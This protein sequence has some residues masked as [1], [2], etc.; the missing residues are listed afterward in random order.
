MKQDA[1]LRKKCLSQSVIRLPLTLD[2]FGGCVFQ[3]TVAVR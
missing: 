3:E 1:P 2:S